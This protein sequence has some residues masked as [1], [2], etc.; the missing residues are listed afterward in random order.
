MTKAVFFD[1]D[2]TLWDRYNVIPDSTKMAI[3]LLRENG[4]KAFICTGRTRGYVTN[5]ELLGIGFDGIV[6]GLGTMIEYDGEVKFLKEIPSNVMAWA[7]ET[8]RSYGM[9]PILEGKDYLYMD[10]VDF[11]SDAYGRKLFAELKERWR[12]I[13]GYEGQWEVNKFSCATLPCDNSV[14]MNALADKFDYIIHTPEVMEF[15]PKGYSKGTGLIHA[16]E[17]IG[18]DPKDSIAIGDSA[19]DIDMFRAAGTSVAMGNGSDVAKA[20]ADIVTTSLHED[21]IYNALVKLGLI[22]IN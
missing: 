12:P 5:E 6:S 9:K 8:V 2:G 14:C 13:E 11:E 16:C 7:I 20:A 21:G 18:I 22:D 15:M 10:R 3:R 19:N 4:H 1:I 17:I